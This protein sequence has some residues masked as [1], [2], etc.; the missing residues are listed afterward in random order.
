METTTPYRAVVLTFLGAITPLC[1]QNLSDSTSANEVRPLAVSDLEGR[2]FKRFE[3]ANLPG[4]YEVPATKAKADFSPNGNL[5]L[6]NEVNAESDLESVVDLSTLREPSPFRKVAV[7]AGTSDTEAAA[8]NLP[9][10]L[11][12]LTATY[13]DPGA[14]SKVA[15][16][17]SIGLSVQ[18]QVKLTPGKVL[19]IVEV[20]IT[21]HASCACEIVKAA[22]TAT[23][24]DSALT[25]QIV[26]VA[27]TAAPESMRIISQCAIAT[28]PDSLNEVQAVLA[29]LDPNSGD[30]GYSSKGAKSAKSAKGKEVIPPKVEWPDP[31]DLPPL[32]PPLPPPP[33]NPPP[34]TDVDS[35]GIREICDRPKKDF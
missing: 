9:M 1:A 8:K 35:D 24:A 2:D 4:T 10:G 18:Q 11:A 15:D 14:K 7:A 17:S 23:A 26:E 21:S 13:R 29:K 27:V 16:C 28:V 12:L 19:E 32:G 30:S 33:Y 6:G 20:E 22:L 25:G 34:T 5:A 31:L 3:G